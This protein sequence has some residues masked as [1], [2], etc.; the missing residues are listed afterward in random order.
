MK[1]N[2]VVPLTAPIV[3]AITYI[4]QGLLGK[5]SL[6]HSPKLLEFL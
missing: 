2:G 3:H 1:K 5:V 6:A 4:G